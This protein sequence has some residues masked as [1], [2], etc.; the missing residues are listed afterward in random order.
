MVV[1]EKRAGA[2]KMRLARE[3]A[4]QCCQYEEFAAKR[5]AT[6]GGG[7]GTELIWNPSVSLI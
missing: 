5:W 3:A 6:T 4:G 7:G 2:L 1:D